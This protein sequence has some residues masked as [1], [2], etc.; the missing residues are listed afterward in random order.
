MHPQRCDVCGQPATI[1]ETAIVVGAVVL[2]HFCVVHGA[3]ARDGALQ[4]ATVDKQ[5]A[6]ALLTEQ[7]AKLTGTERTQLAQ[8]QRVWPAARRLQG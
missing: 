8:E 1:H 5:A 6:W 4:L 3:A 2:H 7:Y